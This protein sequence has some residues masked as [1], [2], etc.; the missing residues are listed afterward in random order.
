MAELD[1]VGS[2]GDE[3]ETLGSG[4]PIGVDP[5]T[6]TRLRRERE[7]AAAHRGNQQRRSTFI[8]E[9]GQPARE[10]VGHRAGNAERKAGPGS[11]ILLRVLGAQLEQ[12]Q[13]VPVGGSVQEPEPARRGSAR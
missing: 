12:D 7:V 13:R 11:W 10:G 3:P 9:P 1:P 5:D 4:H 6:S 8:V 2:H